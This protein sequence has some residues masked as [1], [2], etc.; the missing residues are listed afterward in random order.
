MASNRRQR[1]QSR[2]SPAPPAGS[3][4]ALADGLADAGWQLVLDAR[5]ADRPRAAAAG[6]I[7]RGTRV[8]ACPATSPTRRTGAALVA[9]A[10]RLGGLDLLVN[11]AG[12]LGPSPQPPLADYPLDALRRGVRGERGRAARADPARPAGAAGPPAARSSTSAPTRPSRRTRAGAGTARPRPRSSRPAGVLAAEEP[13]AAGVVGRPGRPAD[14]DA[15]GGVPGRGHQRPAA[16]GDG[17]AAP[18]CGCWPTRPPS[19]AASGCADL[20]ERRPPDDGTRWTS[21][22]PAGAGGARA[23]GGARRRPRRRAAAGRASGPP[24]R[25]RH[26]RFTDLPDLLRAGRRAGGQHLRRRCP[27]AVPVVGARLTRPLLHRAAP[28]AAGWSSCAGATGTADRAVRRRRARRAVPRCPAARAVTLRRAVL[29][30]AGCG[31][32]ASDTGG[33]SVL[34]YLHALRRSR[35][36][37]RYVPTGTGRCATYQT[38]FARAA[39][40]RRD[41]ERRRGRSPTELVTRLVTAGVLVA[42]IAAAHRGGLAGGARAAVPGAVRGAAEHRAAGQRGPGGR[43]PG[44]RGRHHGGA[45]AGDGGRADGLVGRRGLDRPGGHAGARGAGGRRPADRPARAAGVAPGHARGGRR[46]RRCWTRCYAA[47][48]RRPATSGTSSAT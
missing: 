21:R 42:P 32:P 35:S 5:G 19:G 38:V 20:L 1:C 8:V 7:R 30:P 41:A 4:R 15:P 46:R 34:D 40:Q 18:S 17:R 14:P 39:G 23:A 12:I 24:A 13:D 47:A 48:L 36:G 3:G 27:A 25:S 44:D 11:N 43:R 22:C 45:G 28:T 9:A 16:A 2:S 26:H 29:A 6:R 10:D 33:R 37:T 31:W